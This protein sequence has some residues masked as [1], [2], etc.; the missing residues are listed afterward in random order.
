MVK[1]S[2]IIPVYNSEQ[3]L[4]EC[5]DSVIAQ[6]LKEIE[7]ICVDDGSTDNC[8]QILEEYAN[9]DFRIMVLHEKNSGS[10]A[11]R[12]K[13]I[14]LASG[15]YVGFVDSDDWIDQEMY[16]KLY[17]YA[18]EGG[19]EFVSSGYIKEGNYTTIQYD[20]VEEGIYRK[21]EIHKLRNNAIYNMQT[22][23][24]GMSGSMCCKLYK[25]DL[26]KKLKDEMPE[27]M[28]FSEDKMCNLLYVLNCNSAHVIKQAFYHYRM[29]K[30]SVVHTPRVDYLMHVDKVYQ[31]LIKL[32]QHVNF[33]HIM[34]Q[35][36]E[37]YIIE[38]LVH[39][40]NQRMGFENRNLFWIDPYWLDEIPEASRIILYGGGELGEKYHRQLAGR[41]D[42]VYAGCVDY[43]FERYSGEDFAVCSPEILQEAEYDHIVITI[44]NPGKAAEVRER[45]IQDGVEEEK[46]LWFEQKEI[47]WK[48]AEAD[49]LLEL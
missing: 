15:E 34:R 2:I 10:A 21:E 16:E 44:K 45:L 8:P 35:Q 1:V 22:K 19:V 6:S 39:G 7:I 3:Y 26:L 40:I 25:A 13:G 17:S 9:K 37:L 36:A 23:A 43:G 30:D 28:A 47:F 49:G 14:S 32:Y 41:K 12:K 5:L 27:G 11:A 48:Y 4:R 24:L 42:L 46:I 38:L 18:V 29:Q 20:N 31:F 33:S